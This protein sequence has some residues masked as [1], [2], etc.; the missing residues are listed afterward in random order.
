VPGFARARCHG[1]GTAIR[2][3]ASGRKAAADVPPGVSRHRVSRLICG[4]GS[5]AGSGSREPVYPVCR[6]LV[7]RH[8]I[9]QDPLAGLR[10]R[11]PAG[12]RAGGCGAKSDYIPVRSVLC[13][14]AESARAQQYPSRPAGPA[15][16]HRPHGLVCRPGAVGAPERAGRRRRRGRRSCSPRWSW[17]SW[18]SRSRNAAGA[19]G[20]P[21]RHGRR[22]TVLCSA[23]SQ[24]WRRPPTANSADIS[25]H[26]FRGSWSCRRSSGATFAFRTSTPPSGGCGTAR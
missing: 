20:E 26:Y 10:L 23:W 22:R 15:G 2:P 25:A 18:L 12:R 19:A 16:S 6:A 8:G 24:A 7:Q 5:P 9:T 14:R 4:R 17:R 21:L 11:R 3:G 1:D 13:D